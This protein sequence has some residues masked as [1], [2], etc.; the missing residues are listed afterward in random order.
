MRANL[1]VAGV[2]HIVLQV[3]PNPIHFSIAGAAPDFAASCPMSS[4]VSE[5]PTRIWDAPKSLAFESGA[6]ALYSD[7]II[8]VPARRRAA[9]R[10]K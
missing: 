7:L 10:V 2:F 1:R 5:I 6:R 4:N 9:Q 3:V 8:G